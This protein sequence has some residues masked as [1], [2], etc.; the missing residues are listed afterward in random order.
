MQEVGTVY[1]CNSVYGTEDFIGLLHEQVN[2]IVKHTW[3]SAEEIWVVT[4]VNRFQELFL[5]T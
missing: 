2:T 3:F 1:I 5:V 4:V